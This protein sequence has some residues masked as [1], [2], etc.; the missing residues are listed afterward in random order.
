MPPTKDTAIV[1]VAAVRDNGEIL[2]NERQQIYTLPEK[3]RA[4]KG[5]PDLRGFIKKAVPVRA[6]LNPK[7]GIVEKIETL[8]DEHIAEFRRLRPRLENPSKARR[9]DVEKLD[10]IAFNVVENLNWPLFNICVKVIPN[11]AKAKQIFDFC[12]QQT[13][14]LGGPFDM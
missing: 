10:P 2:F 14:S 7:R 11:Y 1:T 12:A 4:S 8:P 5:F 9:I 3:L 6:A 13:C